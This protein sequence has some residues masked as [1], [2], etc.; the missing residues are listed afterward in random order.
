MQLGQG[1]HLARLS[2]RVAG[3]MRHLDGNEAA[4]YALLR[5][6]LD[7]FVQSAAE[8]GPAAMRA[9]HGKRGFAAVERGASSGH[10]Q[11]RVEGLGELLNFGPTWLAGPLARPLGP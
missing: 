3:A 4:G 8:S 2:A 5:I 1:A 6:G 9:L 7:D 10:A 11:K